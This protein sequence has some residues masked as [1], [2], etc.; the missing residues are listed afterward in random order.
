MALLS[1]IGSWYRWIAELKKLLVFSG[2]AGALSDLFSQSL[3]S[4][5]G[6]SS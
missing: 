4:G 5:M 6:N 3:S 2:F 1:L